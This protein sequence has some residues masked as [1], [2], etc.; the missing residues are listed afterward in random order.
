MLKNIDVRFITSDILTVNK[1]K[2]T[3]SGEKLI[4]LDL[5][6]EDQ[7]II[8]QP[9]LESYIGFNLL[10][11]INGKLG[12]AYSLR[13]YFLLFELNSGI[14]IKKIEMNKI[15]FLC[16]LENKGRQEKINNRSKY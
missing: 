3:V 16:D 12:T 15:H 5:D 11:Q 9:K 7:T 1:N 14:K 6:K 2:I 8:F 4:I 10:D 13:G